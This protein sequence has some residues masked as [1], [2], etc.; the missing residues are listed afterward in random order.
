M[1]TL[2]GHFELPLFLLE[3]LCVFIYLC[4]ESDLLYCMCLIPSVSIYIYTQHILLII[5]IKEFW[6]KVQ[7]SVRSDGVLTETG[8]TV[9]LL[10]E[11]WQDRSGCAGWPSFSQ[12]LEVDRQRFFLWVGWASVL[13][14]GDQIAQQHPE[15]HQQEP[16]NI[17]Q[18]P[19]WSE[20]GVGRP[21]GQTHGQTGSQE[22]KQRQIWD[23]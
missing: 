11:H 4:I 6:Q 2:I 8:S 22:R 7:Q 1:K 9:S 13:V 23:R 15:T 17:G 16:Q 12:G 21:G 3:A 18:H 20:Q 14:P 10:P 19:L 5:Q